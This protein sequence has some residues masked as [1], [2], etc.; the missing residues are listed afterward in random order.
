MSDRRTIRSLKKKYKKTSYVTAGTAFS[1]AI[2]LALYF[3]MGG[4]KSKTAIAK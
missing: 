2:I 3:L 1:T 4:R